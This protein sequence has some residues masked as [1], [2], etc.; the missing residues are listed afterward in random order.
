MNPNWAHLHLMVNHLPLFAAIAGL[1]LLA[2]GLAKGNPALL[3]AGLVACVLAGVGTYASTFSGHRAE[4]WAQG[5]P[6]VTEEVI[7]EHEEAAEQ[8]QYAAY[9]L[10]IVALFTL[11]RP[12]RSLQILALVLAL[13]T[14][15][16]MVRVAELGGQV[17]HTEIRA[18]AP[19]PGE[20]TG[21]HDREAG[22]HGEAGHE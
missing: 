7:S 15:A 12:K 2:S 1:L 8:S 18:G 13:A 11:F 6:G 4:D 10:G 16:A 3:R 5:M 22:E 9:P 17:R 19:V 14:T 21:G 20:G